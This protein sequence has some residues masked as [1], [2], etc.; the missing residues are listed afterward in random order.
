MNR[1]TLY[2]IG[3]VGA[4]LLLLGVVTKWVLLPLIVKSKI[5]DTVAIK[6]GTEAFERWEKLPVTML[7]RVYLFEV[8]NPEEITQNGAV[9]QVKERGP[10]V[11]RE[12]RW[13]EKIK[14]KEDEDTAEYFQMT[15]FEFDEA[16]SKESE[17]VEMT[18]V[19]V[20][21]LGFAYIAEA[22]PGFQWALKVYNMFISK[23][24]PGNHPIFIKTKVKDYL[25]GSV[26]MF[27]NPETTTE[28]LDP[29]MKALWKALCLAFA[30]IRPE[31]TVIIDDGERGIN[32][33][34][35]FK[36]KKAPDGPYKVRLGVK[37]LEKIGQ[38]MSWQEK[39]DLGT[40][41]GGKTCN[42]VYGTDSTV[43]RPY[44]EDADVLTVFNGDICRTVNLTYKGPEEYKGVPARRYVAGSNVFAS[45][46]EN[47]ENYCYCPRSVKGL[48]SFGGCMK[49][50]LLDL[51]SCQGAPV[52]LS[53]PHFLM[54]DPSYQ[55]M[56]SGLEPDPA[57]H[58][59]FVDLEPNT[60]YPLRGAI[61]VQMNILLKNM[62]DV[63]C[64]K[65]F[66]G[67]IIPMLWLDEGVE[68]TDELVDEVKSRLLNLLLAAD[69][70]TWLMIVSGTVVSIGS[71][72]VLIYKK[73]KGV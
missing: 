38:I 13:K 22:L 58:G 48:T 37:D 61:R 12:K 29:V 52:V 51:S 16:L 49:S 33:F 50:G 60:G 7:F 40:M 18:V 47:P 42:K 27:C 1:K 63:D 44:L 4:A 8:L 62:P 46:Q 23:M 68:L 5:A 55:E 71:I 45:V 24:W 3:A 19:N 21:A 73:R 28:N 69:I 17:E 54:A 9:P 2:I 14:L 30:Y 70:L 59:I 20:P 32:T 57:K 64:M 31:R 15:S 6:N 43:F 35:F 41:W 39:S 34:S 36:Y 10:F 67:K 72:T 66:P 25:F 26:K 65:N 53:F 56:V 11:Y